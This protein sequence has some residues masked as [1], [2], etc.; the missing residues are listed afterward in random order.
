LGELNNNSQLVCLASLSS[1]SSSQ[2]GVCSDSPVSSSNQLG[3][4]SA[5]PQDN[6]NNNLVGVYSAS[7]QVNSS[8][9]WVG[10]YSANLQDN[11]N[12][13]TE[14]FLAN[15]PSSNNQQVAY[16]VNLLNSRNSR[17]GAFLGNLPNNR[18]NSKV[19]LGVARFSAALLDQALNNKPSSN[20]QDCLVTRWPLRT[21]YRHSRRFQPGDS[22][23]GSG[24]HQCLGTN[25]NHN[26][27][28]SSVFWLF[29]KA[30]TQMRLRNR[31]GSVIPNNYQLGSNQNT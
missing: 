15:Q 1:S 22:V 29:Q 7:Q 21:R 31:P 18:S 26:Q 16:S 20:N 14:V 24:G 11:S 6:S 10:V 30:S 19:H 12:N 3:I 17:L 23:G 8:N 27:R 5:S 4:Y 2:R 28:E 13:R 25:H 9:N